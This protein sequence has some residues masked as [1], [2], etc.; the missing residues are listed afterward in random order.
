MGCLINQ[1]EHAQSV[2]S[3]VTIYNILLHARK[4]KIVPTSAPGVKRN[5]K[6]EPDTK[7]GSLS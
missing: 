6:T 7:R 5:L 3:S 2:N 4:K 1:R